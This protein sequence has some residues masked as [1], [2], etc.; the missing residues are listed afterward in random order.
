MNENA[1]K[2]TDN[3]EE[4]FDLFYL[5]KVIWHKR[6]LIISITSAFIVLGVIYAFFIATPMF[7]SSTTLYPAD[8]EKTPNT[9]LQMI[10]AQ[11]GITGLSSTNNYNIPDVVKSRRI[12]KKIVERKWETQSAPR[13]NI[14]LYDFWEIDHENIRMRKELAIEKLGELIS[15]GSDD[16]TGLITISILTEEPQLS[17]NIVNF[18]A[19]EVKNYI[20]NEQQKQ[21]EKNMQFIKQRLSGTKTEL[22]EAEE[23]LKE[24]KEKNRNIAETPELQLEYSRLER[25]IM[26]KQEVY[27]TLE[28][29]KE[30][31]MI[32]ATK[33]EPVINILDIGEKPIK[34]A[35]PKRSMLLIAFTLIGFVIALIVIFIVNLLAQRKFKT[36]T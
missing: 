1:S 9:Q 4:F 30:L 32:E 18:I 16:E 13:E 34:K 25:N 33:E 20:R 21:I 35:K 26:I 27:L 11:F 15:V 6:L 2:T 14:H 24:F 28:K 22:I 31:A 5:I 36:A 8:Q 29:Q 3:D 7:R 23:K 17:A 10:A 19:Q 12:R